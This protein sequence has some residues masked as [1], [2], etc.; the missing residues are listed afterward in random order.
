MTRYLRR[1]SLSIR[2]LALI[3]L[4]VLAI[5]L[6]EFLWGRLFAWSPV[7]PGDRQIAYA[8]VTL[9]LPDGLALPAALAD[10]DAL[11]AQAEQA[12]GLQL[13]QTI[14]VIMVD[15][16][17]EYARYT[18]L[19]TPL[20]CTLTGTVIF[21][22][23]PALTRRD[24]AAAL[25]HELSHALLYQHTTLWG[26]RAIPEWFREGLAGYTGNP[27]DNYTPAEFL[28]LAV[29]QGYLITIP[30]APGELARI[31]AEQRG[32]FK[33]KEWRYFVEYLAVAYG[34][35]KVLQYLRGLLAEPQRASE[36][37]RA[38]FGADL[39][40]VFGR[41]REQVLAKTWPRP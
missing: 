41:F 34:Q 18:G 22:P 19:P 31:P 4:A 2:L 30:E 15:D 28:E 25:K 33:Q 17:A 12:H 23:G 11:V 26:A 32:K 16:S 9:V 37:F 1:K 20:P 27:N 21:L 6:Y 38:T 13:A 14:R 39:A 7:K 36:L 35:E 10:V 24:L 40:T 8:R 29:D 3:L 5:G